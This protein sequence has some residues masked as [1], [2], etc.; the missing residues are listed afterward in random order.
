MINIAI[1]GYAGSGKST[2]AKEL[3]K[4]LGFKV[5]DT[6]AVYRA[7]ACSFKQ[8]NLNVEEISDLYVQRFIEKIEIEVKFINGQQHVFVNNID[9]TDSLRTEE[10]SK[11]TPLLSPFSCVRN[12]ILGLQREFAKN[13]DLVME[14]R[15]IGS[16]ILPEAEFKF[17]CTADEKVRAQRRLEQYL[18]KGK[19]IP[20]QEVLEELKQRDYNDTHRD[21]GAIT[22]L[23]D[24]II[25]DTTYQNLDESVE[26]CLSKIREKYPNI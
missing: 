12:K 25:L 16:F 22:I 15:D 6:G 24:S 26:F 4:R 23:Q 14:G 17:F 1:D 5:F 10:I 8:M 20:F 7:I 19:N 21:H 18:A 9:F 3:A 13:N 2:I 11:L